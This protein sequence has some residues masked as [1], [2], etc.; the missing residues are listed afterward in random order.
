MK[1]IL[2]ML[3]LIVIGVFLAGCSPA[4]QDG[5]EDT[6]LAGEATG[7]T[8]STCL[9]YTGCQNVNPEKVIGI[10]KDGAFMSGRGFLNYNPDGTF[11]LMEV[12]VMFIDGEE[13]LKVKEIPG[14][15]SFTLPKCVPKKL[16]FPIDDCNNCTMPVSIRLVGQSQQGK[17][18]L[19]EIVS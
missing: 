14:P 4:L 11:S 17:V 19:V 2:L 9:F 8:K 16:N 3:S 15:E 18:A 13:L 1:K 5:S 6:A 7:P 10:G 12:N